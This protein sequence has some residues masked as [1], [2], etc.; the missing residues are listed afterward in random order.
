LKPFW[1]PFAGGDKGD[2][3]DKNDKEDKEVKDTPP[4]PSNNNDNNDNNNSSANQPSGPGIGAAI[5]SLPAA[6]VNSLPT[7]TL[8]TPKLTLFST[9]ISH[10]DEVTRVGAS[11]KA[12]SLRT[13]P[14]GQGLVGNALGAVGLGNTK[15]A[16]PQGNGSLK[17]DIVPKPRPPLPGII[18]ENDGPGDDEK[19]AEDEQDDDHAVTGHLF[20]DVYKALALG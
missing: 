13:A 10:M 7:L 8:P 14:E 9:D 6:M 4:G 12:S 5:A 15:P 2:K 20:Y 16:L 17:V 11:D 1:N 19:G 18:L 3:G